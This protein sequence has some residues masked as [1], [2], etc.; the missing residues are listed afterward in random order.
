MKTVIQ[1]WSHRCFNEPTSYWGIGDAIR[2]TI[3]L[4]QLCKSKGYE[5]IVDLS[6]H[7]VSR[8]LKERNHPYKELVAKSKGNIP[9]I[10]HEVDKAIEQLG[11]VVL[12]FSNKQCNEDKIDYECKNF[13]KDILTPRESIDLAVQKILTGLPHPFNV[14]H[15]RLGD[16]QLVYNATVQNMAKYL[17]KML[18]NKEKGDILFSDTQSFKDMTR[19]FVQS[20][21]IVPK[22]LGYTDNTSTQDTMIEFFVMTRSK[23]IK[24]YSVHY[25]I[26]GFV[27]WIHKVYDIPLTKIE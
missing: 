18:D 19:P 25:W 15:F 16:D 14:L 9:I 10:Y 5:L 27:Y 13:I 26:S 3:F 22:H 20:T 17:T 6:H 2:G 4:Y 23:K 12:L 21:S 1:V 24:T 7:T 8:Y 11:T